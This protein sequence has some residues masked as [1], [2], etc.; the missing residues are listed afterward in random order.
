MSTNLLPFVSRLKIVTKQLQVYRLGDVLNHAQYQIIEEVNAALNEQRRCRII[1]L[2]ARQLGV[3]TVTEALMF[4]LAMILHRMSGLVLSHESQ[5]A[6]HLLNMTN[7]YWD[8]WDFKQ[9]YTIK[10]NS[11]QHKS[12]VETGSGIRVATANNEDAGRSQTIHFLHASEV[13]FW[14]YPETLMTGLAQ[15]IP[16]T[17]PSVIIKES[18][19]NGIGGYFYDEWNNAVD[20]ETEDVPLFFPWHT[21]PEYRASFIGVSQVLGALDDEER[22]LRAIG[23]DDDRLAWRRWHIRNKCQGDINK[24]HQ[25]MP[26]TPEEAFIVTGTNIFSDAELLVCYQPTDG[27]RGRLTEEGGRVRF[28]PSVNGPVTIFKHPGDDMNRHKYMISGDATRS[29]QGDFSCAQVLNRRTWEQVAVFHSRIDP[30]AFGD[31]MALLGRY[32]NWAILVPEIQGAGDATI[33]RLQSLG[34]PFLFEHRKAE[35]IPGQPETTFGWWAGV[36][37]KQE[38]MGNLQKAVN[39]HDIVIHHDQ[40]YREMRAYVSDGKGG[41][42]NGASEKHD[43]TVTAMAICI[44]AVMYEALTVNADMGRYSG[45]ADS[46]LRRELAGVNAAAAALREGEYEGSNWGADVTVDDTRLPWDDWQMAN[47]GDGGDGW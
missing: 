32:Y 9:L 4:T 18:T 8:T 34:Y 31:Q 12:W 22:V 27:I 17:S 40:T 3:S 46:E 30:V 41:F 25:E 45:T 7:T 19:A 5:S 43:D 29:V 14:M 33:A 35:K 21:H 2:K 15:S 24:F 13:A 44:T 1:V 6:A 11:V 28:Q 47:E 37:A 42:K 20:G 26:T 36:R 38:A 23:I 39:D 10:N 16:D